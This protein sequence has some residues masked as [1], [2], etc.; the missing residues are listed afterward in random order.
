MR[1]CP[2]CSNDNCVP[3]YQDRKRAIYRCKACELLFADANSHLPPAA[4]LNKYQ[5][6]ANKHK[7]LQQFVMS[8]LEQCAQQTTQPLLGLN[9]GRTLETSVVNTISQRG[10]QL[11]QYDPFFA[12]DHSL[13]KQ[14]YDFIACYKVFEH[15]RFPNKEWNL[16]CSILKPGG[17]IAINTQL[18][19]QLN[20]FAKWHHKNN[21]THVSFYQ[22]AT[23]QFLAQQADFKL[24][25]ASNDLIL[26]QKPSKSDIT[27]DPSSLI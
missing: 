2:L 26:V 21:L 23:F 20:G 17:W 27:R 13:L 8:L 24:L 22:Q 15:F 16:L 25:F 14:Q 18:L 1:R 4:E 10:H 3:F 5:T 12:P 19:V 7:A 9:F 11:Y 6:A